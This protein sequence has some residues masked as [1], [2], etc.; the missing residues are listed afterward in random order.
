MQV[1]GLA[2]GRGI[3]QHLGRRKGR[4]LTPRS[5]FCV[6]GEGGGVGG[7]G[8]MPIAVYQLSKKVSF[9]DKHLWNREVLV[10]IAS[11]ATIKLGHLFALRIY[12]QILVPNVH[13]TQ[14]RL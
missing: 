9:H 5:F 11:Q 13:P 4:H 12:V 1:G 7:E 8:L 3:P 2:G 14:R 10:C 6:C